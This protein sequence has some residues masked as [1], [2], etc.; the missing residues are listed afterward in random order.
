MEVNFIYYIGSKQS[1][2][3]LN[4]NYIIILNHHQGVFNIPKMHDPLGSSEEQHNGCDLSDLLQS[5]R[6]RGHQ[7]LGKGIWM[8]LHVPCPRFVAKK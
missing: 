7:P 3:T 5:S 4:S 2:F 1:K 6:L 8:G